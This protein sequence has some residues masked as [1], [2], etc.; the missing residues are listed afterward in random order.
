MCV[1]GS[2]N[3]LARWAN[4]SQN[5][6]LPLW[7]ACNDCLAITRC[8]LASYLQASGENRDRLDFDIDI[9]RKSRNLDAR[10]GGLG[11]PKVLRVDAI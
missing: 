6:S 7:R 3:W 1:G 4:P 11:L 10:S 9:K 2:K 5:T 8:L